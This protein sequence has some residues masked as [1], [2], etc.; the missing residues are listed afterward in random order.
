MKTIRLTALIGACMILCICGCTSKQGDQLTEKQKE[1]IKKEIITVYDSI[2]SKLEKLDVEQSCQYYTPDC[3]VF[4][5]D[6]EQTSFQDYK[7]W[8]IDVYKSATSYKWISSG[9]VFISITRDVV[10]ISLDG[11]NETLMNSGKMFVTEPS[12]YTWAFKKTN[13]Q[14]KLFYHHFSGAFLNK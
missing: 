1:Q 6:G 2:F 4:G 8:G 5:S 14:W 9:P 7:K 12:H 11:R 10:L 3:M 13:G